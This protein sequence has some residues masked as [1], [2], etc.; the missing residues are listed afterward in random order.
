MKQTLLLCAAFGLAVSA[1]SPKPQAPAEHTFITVNDSGQFVRDGK[2]YYYVGANF[3]Y[4]AIL[5]STGRGG[6]R[7][8]LHRE[9]DFLKDIGVNNLRVLVGADGPDGVKTRVEPSLQREPGV[10]N[11]TI[12]DG[13]DY[14]MNELKKRDMTAVLYLN[15]SW[16][17]SG[18]YSLYLQ[19][20]GHGDAVVPAICTVGQR[21]GLVCQTRGLHR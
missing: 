10:Y 4:G 20:T 12:P 19:W 7:E 2:P 1:C 11:D 14:F 17:W 6:D 16:E 18:G 8:R 9:L 13:L 21:A 3:W 15:N 5:G